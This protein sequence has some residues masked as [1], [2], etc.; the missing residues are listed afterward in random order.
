MNSWP[1]IA[2]ALLMGATGSIHCV[3][4]CSALQQTAVHGR[5]TIA[6]RSAGDGRQDLWFQAGRVGG[7]TMLGL[8][9]GV[10]GDWLLS[11]AALQPT[12]R[13]VWAALNALLLSIGLS[14]LV[15]GRQ[16]SWL[17]RLDAPSLWKRNQAAGAAAARASR[18]AG[19]TMALRGMLWALLPCGLLYSALA[20][21][22]LAGEPVGA[23]LV[24]ASF[25]LG[26]AGGLLFFQGALRSLAAG[27]R[28]RISPAS[29]DGLSLR[30]GG[31]LLTVMAGVALLAAL[32][33]Q[34]NPFC[35]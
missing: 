33:G 8:L 31:L 24:M 25:G 30:V 13:S 17:A 14:M 27:L 11:A 10:A 19:P 35:R 21:A 29:A 23:A 18:A 7:Y 9:A 4:M 6:I 2:S 12:F 16:P 3:A 26:T 20:L 5:P 34:G 15:S 22:I 1:L 32:A 28:G